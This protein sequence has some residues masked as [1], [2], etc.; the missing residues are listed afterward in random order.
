MTIG[1]ALMSAATMGGI[2]WYSARA[3]LLTAAGDRLQLA[4]SARRD[5]IEL[6]AER[7]HADFVAVAAHPQ[8]VSNFPDLIETLDPGKSDY[9]TVIEAF[10]APKTVEE[11]IALDGGAGTGMYGR[12]HGKVQEI[13][14]KLVAQRAMATCSSSMKTAGSPTPR[15]RAR[16]SRA[17]WR[18]VRSRRPVSVASWSG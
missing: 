12:R 8:V 7:M 1:L 6:T 11:R 4:A 14:R 17:P 2:S 15:P 5:S 10:R 18:R 9:A 16:I 13:A 3:S